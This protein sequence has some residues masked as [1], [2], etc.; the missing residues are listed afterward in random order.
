MMAIDPSGQIDRALDFQATRG[1]I[2]GGRGGATLRGLEA[3]FSQPERIPA[4]AQPVPDQQG[5]PQHE[6]NSE[7]PAK[8]RNGAQVNPR[9]HGKTF[10]SS[11]KCGPSRRLGQSPPQTMATP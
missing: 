4:K 11:S 7:A 8:R 9:R 10:R 1:R 6:R 2:V 5:G 3:R